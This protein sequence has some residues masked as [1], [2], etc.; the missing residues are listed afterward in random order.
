MTAFFDYPK[1]AEF[2]RILPKSKIY[3]HARA[4]S[5]LQQ[6][7]VDQVEKI[8]WKVKLAPETINLDAT[9]TVLEIQVFEIRLRTA[10]C[11]EDILRAI[12]KA[13]PFPIIFEL[14]HGGK[15]KVVAAYKRPPNNQKS[16]ANSTKWVVSEY[17]DTEWQALDNP[18]AALPTALDL[19]ALYDK[20]LS[21]LLPGE[22]GMN[23][24]VAVRVE[25]L[26][27]IRAGER[28]IARIK[29]RMTREKQYN[30]RI[31][32]NAELRAAQQELE[33]LTGQII[34]SEKGYDT[35]T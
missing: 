32:I 15:C 7:F 2:S 10:V 22:V 18:R 14:S 35:W 30:K 33:Q 17:F 12:D 21:G 31:A 8:I 3:D 26:E 28:E 6:L 16:E 20:L 1:A 4:S 25:N 9:K 34:Q 11:D 19:G 23:A 27:A 24:P 13:I 29:A 5:K